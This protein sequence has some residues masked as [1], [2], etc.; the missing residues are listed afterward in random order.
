[1]S[2]LTVFAP[3]TEVWATP[4]KCAEDEKAQPHRCV[5]LDVKVECTSR[6]LYRVSPTIPWFNQCHPDAGIHSD[7]LFA[8]EAEA[9]VA[10]GSSLAKA[11]AR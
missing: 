1:M 5:I 11:K 3:G 2:T 7:W 8:T 9:R 4:N 6:V 10:Y